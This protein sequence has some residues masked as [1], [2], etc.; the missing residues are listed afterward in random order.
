MTLK[1]NWSG[2]GQ[3]YTED[4]IAAV[5]DVLRNADGLTLGPRLKKFEQDFEAML[6]G[7]RRCFGLTNCASALELAA[8][9]TGVGPGDEVIIPAHTYCATAIPFGRSGAK[10][11]WGDIDPDTLL[12]S[13][14]S[15]KKL[16]TPKTKAIVIVHL[17]GKLSEEMPAIVAFARER[18]IMVIEDC[19][20]S[21]GASF[22]GVPSGGF[23]DIS[24]FSFHTQKNLTTM[25]EGGMIAVADPALVAKVDGLRHNGHVPFSGSEDYWRPAMVNVVEDLPGHWPHNFSMCE[26]QAALGSAVL[27]RLPAMTEAR[28]QR[29]IKFRAAMAD[30]PELK[31][32]KIGEPAAHSHHLLPARFTPAK[33]GVNRDDLIRLLFGTHGIKCVVQFYPLYRYDLFKTK[34]AGTA[35]CPN[36]D[37]F[38]D[39]MLSFPFHVH[40]D[41]ESFDYLIASVKSAVAS[42]R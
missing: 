34:G 29:G 18:G 31:F 32:Q 30:V 23:G 13:L 10:L 17:Y 15:I 41:E 9:L 22:G 5:V 28:R 20:Q 14:D 11:V 12:L 36:T 24:C 6:G 16:T 40:M 27:P 4:E 3:F 21:L 38:F 1:I 25:G 39:N 2:R 42:L 33:A 19:A 35:D 26:A 37:A 7:G 8:I